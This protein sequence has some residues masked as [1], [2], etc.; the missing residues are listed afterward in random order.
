MGDL[1]K[2]DEPAEW[3]YF[4]DK[5]DRIAYVRLIAF[6]DHSAGDLTKAIARL[7]AEGVRGLVIDLRDNPG[8]LLTSAVEIAN[9]FI[10]D[11]AIVSVRDRRGKGK[12]YEAKA[13]KVHLEPSAAHPL[14]VLVNKDSASASEI[15]AAALQDH[16]RA[17]IVGERTYGKGSVQNII[18]LPDREPKVALKLT[19]ASYW[20]PNGA[21]IHRGVDA[22]ET[23]EWGVKPNPGYEVKLK[24]E[25]R[26]KYRIER[27]KRDIVLG[28]PGSAPIKAAPDLKPLEDKVLDKAMEYLRGELKKG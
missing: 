18:E 19:T 23:D 1:R 8:G 11:G 25:E 4:I 24:L 15:V 14:A 12:S 22:K 7:E 26:A 6:N 10:K 20:R 3:D 28:K 16:Q 21:N 27:R 17:A 13:N 9:L 2:A 5:T